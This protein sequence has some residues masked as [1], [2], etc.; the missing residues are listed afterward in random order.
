MNYSRTIASLIVSLLGLA[1]YTLSDSTAVEV[2]GLIV[3]VGGIGAAWF[4][5]YLRG[6]VSMWGVKSQE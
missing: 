5:R 4:F 6:D 2:A 3:N 1:G